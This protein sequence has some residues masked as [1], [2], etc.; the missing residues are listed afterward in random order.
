M[1]R[2]TPNLR[3]HQSAPQ[4]L[5]M[6][7]CQ[8]K[9]S[10]SVSLTDASNNLHSYTHGSTH[11]ILLPALTETSGAWVEQSLI[12]HTL[13]LPLHSLRARVHVKPRIPLF[14]P[15]C[16]AIYFGEIKKINCQLDTRLFVLSQR[17]SIVSEGLV[18]FLLPVKWSFLATQSL[19][20]PK[21]ATL[22]NCNVLLKE[23]KIIDLKIKGK[24]KNYT[25]ILNSIPSNS[26]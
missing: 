25:L 6:S 17:R 3:A 20:W 19:R 7:C 2:R 15:N 12:R 21:I 8:P 4:V 9:H 11:R 23:T 24:N 22:V 5:R 1:I 10:L 18:V 16:I 14:F 13:L 26:V